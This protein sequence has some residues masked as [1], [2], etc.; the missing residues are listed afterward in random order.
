[1]TKN[2]T[3]KV[4]FFFKSGKIFPKKKKSACS[5]FFFY[6]FLFKKKS[7]ISFENGVNIPAEKKKKLRSNP[8]P[9]FLYTLILLYI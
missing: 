2:K 5:F 4:I 6:V 7:T 1:M 8:K 3:L 9:R